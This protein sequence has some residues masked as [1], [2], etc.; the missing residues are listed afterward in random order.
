MKIRIPPNVG[1]GRTSAARKVA[2]HTIRGA[3]PPDAQAMYI[4]AGNNIQATLNGNVG[5]GGTFL[6]GA[7]IH[8]ITTAIAPLNNQTL[9]GQFGAVIRGSVPLTAWT[10]SGSDW[11]APRA[12][13]TVAERPDDPGDGGRCNITGCENPN[14]VFR[15]GVPL[16]RVASQGALTTGT[17]WEDFAQGRV[18][19]RDN[20]GGALVEQAVA[21]KLIASSN[22]NVKVK[23]LVCEHAANLAQTGAVDAI[24]SN[25]LIENCDIRYNHGMGLTTNGDNGVARS[26]LIHHQMQIGAGGVGENCLWE[27]ND[28]YSNNRDQSY[29]KGWEAGGS[30]WADCNHLVLRGNIARHNFGIGLWCDINLG[31]TTIEQNHVFN[32]EEWGIFYEIA[33]GEATLGDGLKTHIRQNVAYDN[34]TPPGSTTGFWS[35]GQIVVS[36]SR[37]CEVY[38]NVVRGWDGIGGIAQVRTDHPD[39]RGSHQ[40]HNLHV[41]DN[42]IECTYEYPTS[43]TGW[44]N[45][46]GIK[47]DDTVNQD[48]E[49]W[50][51]Q[52]NSFSNND[53]F[54]PNSPG[55]PNYPHWT[56][57]ADLGTDFATFSQ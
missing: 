49:V 47:T 14:D 41:Y 7:G 17:F 21:T 45:A 23:N 38:S 28:I 8:R 13:G 33:Y 46:G 18:Y 9:I 50:T 43:G 56:W 35:S 36:A 53:Y 20:P 51:S 52:G 3:S 2:R 31:H 30:K 48:P 39:S 54:V 32:N 57:R 19:I 16:K 22:I 26:N 1:G 42:Q 40:L 27:Y 24:G 10:Q 5:G 44:G 29:L 37:D 55:D 34:M 6:L 11:W 25:W 4:P 12:A 15:N